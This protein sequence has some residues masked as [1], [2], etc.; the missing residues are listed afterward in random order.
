MKKRSLI[1]FYK[2][3]VPFTEYL[4]FF[5]HTNGFRGECHHMA[6]HLFHH[7]AGNQPEYPVFGAI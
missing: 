5:I 7:I 1:F 3:Q 2:I 6:N 4:I